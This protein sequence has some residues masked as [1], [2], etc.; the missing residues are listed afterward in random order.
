MEQHGTRINSI[1]VAL[2]GTPIAAS[3]IPFVRELAWSLSARVLVMS[4]IDG[5]VSDRFAKFCEA[6]DVSLVE[7]VRAYQAGLVRDLAEGGIACRGYVVAFPEG[8]TSSAILD[9]ADELDA[10]LIVIA[11]HGRSGVRRAVLGSVAEDLIRSGHR[12]VL[13]VRST[14]ADLTLAETGIS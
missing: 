7:A 4:V 9:L 11:S 1:A 12:P 10:S 14:D 8:S 3:T 6:E 2:D 5:A 13:V